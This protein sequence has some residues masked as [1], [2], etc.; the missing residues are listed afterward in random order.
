MFIGQYVN[1]VL[2]VAVKLFACICWANTLNNGI[3]KI[4]LIYIW[5]SQ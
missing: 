2:Q 4:Q 5:H 1:N 3:D